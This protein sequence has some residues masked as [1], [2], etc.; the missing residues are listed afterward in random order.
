MSDFRSCPGVVPKFVP[1][2]CFELQFIRKFIRVTNLRDPFFEI[3]HGILQL[4]LEC[5]DDCLSCL[6]L[7]LLEFFELDADGFWRMRR[8]TCRTKSGV[9]EPRRWT[10]VILPAAFNVYSLSCSATV[11][12]QSVALRALLTLV[13][14]LD[15][16]S[17]LRTHRSSCQESIYQVVSESV[18]HRCTMTEVFFRHDHLCFPNLNDLC[19]LN[20]ITC[21]FSKRGIMRRSLKSVFR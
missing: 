9:T 13:L 12:G 18:D 16:P 2:R 19:F 3:V 10:G 15:R 17:C 5:S 11:P 8:F 7:L 20:S 6:L 14:T 1:H 4:S 21:G